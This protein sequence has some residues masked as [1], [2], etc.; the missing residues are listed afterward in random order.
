M[1][2]HVFVA[3]MSYG[4]QVTLRH[5]LRASACELTSQ[6]ALETLSRIQMRNVSFETLDG[7]PL[8]M[9]SY[10]KPQD[11][12][13]LLHHLNMELPPQKPPKIYSEQLKK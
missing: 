6:A 8:L 1:D 11:D 13:K 3:F 9:Q 4:L 10:T 2:A 7:L 12:Q 5:K